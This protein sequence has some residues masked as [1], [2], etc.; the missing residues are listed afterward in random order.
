MLQ[1]S[2]AQ[3]EE[4]EKEYLPFMLEE[5]WEDAAAAGPSAAAAAA[6]PKRRWPQWAAALWRPRG[7]E[8][9]APALWK[10]ASQGLSVF[11]RSVL[12]QLLVMA[13]SYSLVARSGKPA[14]LA[15]HQVG[16]GCV[17]CVACRVDATHE[18]MDLPTDDQLNSW[19]CSYGSFPPSSWTHS[20]SWGRCVRVVVSPF[21]NNPQPHPKHRHHQH[22]TGPRRRLPGPGARGARPQGGPG[23]AALRGG[24]R[25]GGGA[26]LLG[27]GAVDSR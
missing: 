13:A 26:G 24:E 9:L 3:E 16:V 18:Y 12:Y 15:A 5:E 7:S 23:P 21:K 14:E 27:G 4:E 25:R 6:S 20:P 22:T 17:K 2:K 1:G 8:S 10:F 11:T 19:A